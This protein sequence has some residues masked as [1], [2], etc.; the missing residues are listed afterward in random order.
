MISNE[1]KRAI[2]RMFKS[3]CKHTL[4]NAQ[5]DALREKSRYSKHEKLISDLS[6]MELNE[7]CEYFDY[8]QLPVIFNVFGYPIIVKNIELADAIEA[9]DEGD[10]AIILLFY[11]ADW[12]D[13]R[14]GK[15]M[16]RPRSTVQFRRS[17]ALSILRNLLREGGI[18]HDS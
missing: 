11:F 3:Y 16:N 15:L 2:E 7:L 17:R 6:Y 1:E 13:G 5:I 12:S 9:L 14:I 18:S 4:R 8:E 10:R